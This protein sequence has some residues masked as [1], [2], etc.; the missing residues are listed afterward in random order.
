MI[1]L[2]PNQ[3]AAADAVELAWCQG[4]KRPLIDACVGSGKS[5]TYAELARRTINRGGRVIIGAHTREL[6][7]QNA[8]ACRDLMPGVP[9]GINAA[10][11]GERTWRA[12]IISCA[13]QSIYKNARQFGPIDLLQIDEAHL[14]PHAES[15]M[16]RELGREIG[17]TDGRC[18]IVGGSGTVFRLQGG[19]LVEGEAA[20]FDRVVFTYSNS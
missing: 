14:V 2:R 9:V 16:Y 18:R 6:V 1:T 20:P 8:R 5:Y 12:P 3:I 10:A 7:E 13:I 17:V 15:G 11:L 19:S 4:V